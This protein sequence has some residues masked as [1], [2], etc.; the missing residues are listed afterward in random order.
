M[1]IRWL[2]AIAILVCSFA[3]AYLCGL[4]ARESKQPQ[5]PT[6]A[7]IDGLAVAAADLDVGEVW[8]EKGVTWRLPI[9]NRTEATIEIRDFA[10]SCDCTEVK[11]RKLSLPAGQ[12]ATID[13]TFDLTHRFY[14]DSGLA[15]RPL[16]VTIRPIIANSRP[17]GP[18]WQLHGTIKS[19]ITLDT[20]AVDFGEQPIHGQTPVTQKVHATVHVPCRRLHVALK[21]DVATV[22]VTRQKGDETR[23]ELAISPN[24]AL[25]PGRFKT[26]AKISVESPT[27]ERELAIILPISGIMQ[28]EVRLLPSRLLM[29]AK[30][31]GET[32][33]AIVTLQAPTES[34]VV[35]DHVETESPGLRVE[36]T[37][38]DGIPAGRAFRVRQQVMKEGEQRSEARFIFRKPKHKP[39]LFALTVEICYR[40]ESFKKVVGSQRREKQP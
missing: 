23:F 5:P 26:D 33:E 13:L 32:T 31:V 27:G 1:R 40:G 24:P 25:E 18:G 20:S 8:E 7:V 16:A 17:R 10:T 4:A 37:P 36:P 14:S 19:R 11:P 9:R 35:I 3:V 38:I 15:Q 30:P 21:R 12:A 2:I 39:E 22:M 6:E 29:E 34:K 28:P